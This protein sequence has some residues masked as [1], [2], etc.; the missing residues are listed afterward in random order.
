MNGRKGIRLFL[1]VAVCV[2][3]NVSGRRL[4]TSFALPLWLDTVG[5][6]AGILYSG[7]ALGVVIAILTAV[8]NN[9][10]TPIELLYVLVSISIAILAGVFQKKKKM[11]STLGKAAFFGFWIS[12]LSVAVSVP[13][14]M[15]L[16]N[17]YSGNS[18]GDT[19]VDMLL[20]HGAG[21]VT[22]CIAGELVVDFYDKQLSIF[23]LFIFDSILRFILKK[24]NKNTFK[25]NVGSG[26]AAVLAIITAACVLT[27]SF[28]TLAESNLKMTVYDR[29]NGLMSSEANSV[30]ET[31]DGMIWIGCY[32]GLM[33]YDG[34]KFTY[35][36][37]GGIANVNALYKDREGKLWIGTNDGGIAVYS[38]NHYIFYKAADGL[39]SESIRCFGED[40]D[41]NILVGTSEEMAVIDDMGNIS[42][43]ENK[44][45]YVNSISVMDGR[46]ICSDNAGEIWL[47]SEDMHTASK[48]TP[49][50]YY[51]NTVAT[52]ADSIYAGTSEGV[53]LK[54][55]LS[56][57]ELSF[58]PTI[59][60]RIGEIKSIMEDSQHRTW[61]GGQNGIGYITGGIYND[62]ATGDFNTSVVSLLEDYQGNIWAASGDRGVLKLSECAFTTLTEGIYKEVTNATLV[63]NGRV[64]CATDKGLYILG[65]SGGRIDNDLTDALKGVRIRSL[66]ETSDGRLW[67][68]TYG[69]M[70]LII[71]DGEEIV[72]YINEDNSDVTSDRF[73]CT[74]E[75]SDG[76]IAAGTADG[77]NFFKNDT[78]TGTITGAD[79]LGN[80]QILT[81]AEDVDGCVLAGTD[82]AGIYY[83]KDGRIT[84]HIGKEDGLN[85]D[86]ILRITPYR[87][88]YFAVTSNSISY[89][90]GKNESDSQVTLISNFPYNNNFD[91]ILDGDRAFVLSSSGIYILDVNEMMENSEDMKYEFFG[92]QSG[93]SEA[94]V[95][96]SFG[97]LE[98]GCLTFCTNSGVMRLDHSYTSD[99]SMKFGI[100]AV[101]A[102]ELQIIPDGTG[103]YI[104]PANTVSVKVVPSV[105]NYSMNG[106][107][108]RLNVEGVTD[109]PTMPYNEMV[110]LSLTNLKS[111]QYVLTMELTDESGTQVY[112]KSTWNVIKQSHPWESTAYIH[113]ITVIAIAIIAF[114]T[115]TIV[116]MLENLS[117]KGK[118]EKM[119]AELEEKVKEQTAVI[120][121]REEQTE[122]LLIETVEA[123][124]NTIDAKD[125]YTSGHTRRVARYSKMLAERL[126]KSTEEQELIYRAGLLHDVGK[127]RVPESVIN[128]PG[129]L[130]KEEYEQMKLHPISGYRIISGISWDRSIAFGARFHHER[131]DGSGYPDGR[132][133]EDIPEIARIIGVADAYDAMTSNRS[134]RNALPQEVVKEE[135]IKGKGKQFD[136]V[137]ADAMIAMMDEDKDYR[138]RQEDLRVKRVL[139][140][141]DD[142]I[143]VMIAQ[144]ILSK[145]RNC[146]VVT[147]SD[148]DEGRKKLSES[149]FDLILVDIWLPGESGIDILGEIRGKYLTPVI[150]MSGDKDLETFVKAVNAGAVDFITKPFVPSVLQEMVSYILEDA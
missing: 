94:I 101:Y 17:G 140:I 126:G 139:V 110:P 31:D 43:L 93:L 25:K 41:G 80:T 106:S 44:L 99:I 68:S 67:I 48:Q 74:F 119:K 75:L 58:R 114:T 124:T 22:A 148:G 83:I 56:G 104:I 78:L 28:D 90:T 29:N 52:C 37:E 50:D 72:K 54:V 89:V 55:S 146:E 2:L 132:A 64:Y 125:S 51:I 14:N 129:K 13:I 134:Y 30:A 122:K 53:L 96:N 59:A 20:W 33:C 84:G 73:R 118:L 35:I 16:Y 66:Y 77:L 6:F 38:D 87:D 120:I 49:D 123:L 103:T 60:L 92:I 63:Y 98:N 108:V 147:A 141:D 62:K 34:Y 85:S 142:S 88:G 32:A 26:T 61:V 18:W 40:K 117:R 130:S 91:I 102:D 95:A 4:A 42:V 9:I 76:T 15:A 8:I 109:N 136:P 144:K 1:I 5:T 111:G 143:S 135:L 7:T 39:P 57:D 81:L 69:G 82:G 131:Y 113:Y 71:S 27:S 100:S 45:S 149:R 47:L 19:T 23:L 145:V 121:A 11:F 128:K 79:G 127:I 65:K 46:V 97:Y 3:I 10:A 115:W 150:C 137:I 133:G 138:M 21:R 24:C 12:L 70:G 36:T 86:I 107:Y 105:R 112:S 116:V